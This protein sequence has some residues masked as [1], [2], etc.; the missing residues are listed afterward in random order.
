M[1]SIVNPFLLIFAV[2]DTRVKLEDPDNDY[3]NAN[4]VKVR[5]HARSLSYAWIVLLLLQFYSS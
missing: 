5:M 1:Y 3:I 4:H 2:D